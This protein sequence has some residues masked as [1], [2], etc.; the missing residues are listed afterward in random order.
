[1]LQISKLAM[2]APKD[3]SMD[4]ARGV[5][6]HG[7]VDDEIEVTDDGARSFD[8]FGDD[9]TASCSQTSSEGV[10]E[11]RRGEERA[12]FEK[13]RRYLLPGPFYRTIV[14]L[15]AER[16][17]LVFFW[18]HFISTIVVWGKFRRLCVARRS[19]LEKI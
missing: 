13:A 2:E 16:K 12:I 3:Q 8:S 1:L 14:H 15:Y 11:G 5:H 9:G 18:V 10:H 17:L 7:H 6:Q 19:V 4:R